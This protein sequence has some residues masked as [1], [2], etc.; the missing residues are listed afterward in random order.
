M[1][2][3]LQDVLI[4]EDAT[5]R[6]ALMAID[7]GA[8]EIALMVTGERRLLGSLTDG[9]IRRALLA[10][11]E[12]ED[13]ALPFVEK[14]P[15]IVGPSTGRAEILDLMRARRISQVPVV[16]E[17][18]N[19]LG[20]HLMQELLGG[21]DR[22]NWAVIMAGGRGTRLG[23]L[24]ERIPK[25]MLLVAGRPILERLVLHLVGSGV[26]TI[27]LSVGYLSDKIAAHFGDGSSFGCTIEY[28]WESESQPLGTAG[29]L[30]LLHQHGYEP[31]DP[32]LVMNGDLVTEFSVGS[33]LEKHAS[34]EAMATVAVR[35][36][37]Y[38]VPFGVTE[39]E[40]ESLISLTEKPVASWL[41]NAGIY[42][43]EPELI[44][45]LPTDRPTQ[46][47]ELLEQSVERGERVSVWRLS[48]DWHDVGIPD[49]LL[50]ARGEI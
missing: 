1:F 10:G 12:L 34:T 41:I 31:S 35:E 43:L 45:R 48:E 50:R 46:M 5:I 15:K 22:P 28:L 24:T 38:T 9:D 26:R 33:F 40:G 47:P 36:H 25:P 21:A 7:R 14:H 8:V 11:A 6:D 20:L 49:D 3:Q 37:G 18:G 32:L 16:D 27:F 39:T 19:L 2:E 30:G 13:Q 4:K 29:S 17:E 44:T 23:P 42:V